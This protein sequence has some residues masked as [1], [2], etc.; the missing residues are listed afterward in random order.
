MQ[1]LHL[2][3]KG[4]VQGV[5]YRATARK[6]AEKLHLTGWVKNT[7]DGHVEACVTGTPE[8]IKLFVNWCRQ[9]PANA[10]VSEVAQT[11]MPLT[12][13]NSFVIER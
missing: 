7:G 3:I 1:T 10:R 9:G 13:F 6:E 4:K 5:F 12:T 11:M 2:L 8:A